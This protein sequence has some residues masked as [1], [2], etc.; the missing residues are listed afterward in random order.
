M[1]L[2]ARVV[3]RG[4]RRRIG[5]LGLGD[6]GNTLVTAG[7]QA[8]AVA[9][10]FGVDLNAVGPATAQ[11]LLAQLPSPVQ[12]AVNNAGS[13]IAQ[14]APAISV[15]EALA[16]GKSVTALEV[17]GAVGATVGL[18]NPIAGAAVVAMGT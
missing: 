17:V 9:G 14:G 7:Q 3:G 11:G 16:S 4:P 13:Y 8:Q 5:R 15:A 12:T 2:P 10:K 6:A 1:S 18:V